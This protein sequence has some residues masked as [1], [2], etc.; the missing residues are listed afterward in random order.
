MSL[1][2]S[3][4]FFN[5]LQFTFKKVRLYFTLI[6]GA[7]V[8]FVC[9]DDVIGRYLTVQQ[10]NTDSNNPMHFC[11]IVVNGYLVGKFKSVKPR[12]QIN[13]IMVPAV[14]NIRK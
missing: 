10:E 3:S 2:S 11:E 14:R 4:F 7:T 5:S 12:L 6:A 9:D 1:L 8:N 13:R